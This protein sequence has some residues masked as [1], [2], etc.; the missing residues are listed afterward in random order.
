MCPCNASA[1]N[2]SAISMATKIARI[3]G[4]N[5]SV[6]SWIW[7]SAWN[8][9]MATPTARP[10]S[11]SGLDTITSVRMASRATSSTSGPD[12][13][14]RSPLSFRGAASSAFTRV[15]DAL[16]RRTRNPD[17]PAALDFGFAPVARPGMTKQQRSADQIG[18]FMISS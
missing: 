1:M 7:V 2:G 6:I 14:T 17:N 8:S 4:T 15:F 10:I 18:I 3:F 12:I 16:W 11:I 5:T 9:E 13:D